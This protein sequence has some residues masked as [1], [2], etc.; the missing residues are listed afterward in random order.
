LWE[1]V[2]EETAHLMASRERLR[3]RER[4]H[5]IFKGTPLLT[6]LFFHWDLPSKIPQAGD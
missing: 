5:I 3:E 4:P 1:Y 2:E 6:Y